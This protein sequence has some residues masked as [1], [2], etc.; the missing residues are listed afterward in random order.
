MHITT[1]F[2]IHV[3]SINGLN[4]ARISQQIWNPAK[5]LSSL[6]PSLQFP[7]YTPP[8]NSQ[9]LTRSL[10]N[11][12]LIRRC[13]PHFCLNFFSIST[14]HSQ[15][16]FSLFR[17]RDESTKIDGSHDEQQVLI[18]DLCFFF[19]FFDSLFAIISRWCFR[20]RVLATWSVVSPDH[21]RSLIIF[22]I[23]L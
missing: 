1:S 14:V 16:L 19:L 9:R 11:E 15:I 18:T 22:S 3:S 2:C 17:S 13:F 6:F 10:T 5:I 7:L 4:P 21:H 12:T 8:P 23:F 20:S